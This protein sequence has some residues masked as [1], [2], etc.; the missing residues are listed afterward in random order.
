MTKADK[1]AKATKDAPSMLNCAKKAKRL[2]FVCCNIIKGKSRERCEFSK[3]RQELYKKAFKKTSIKNLDKPYTPSLV[4]SSCDRKMRDIVHG[5]MEAFK[6][7]KWRKPNKHHDDCFVCKLNIPTSYR[8]Y[9]EI[10]FPEDMSCD[11][12]SETLDK[13]KDSGDEDSESDEE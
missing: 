1:A 6:P 3:G 11:L 9:K 10:V 5:K 2:C 4:C 13:G 12:P 7:A 8:K